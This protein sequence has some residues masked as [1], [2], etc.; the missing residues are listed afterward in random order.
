MLYL[1]IGCNI[2]LQSLKTQ[3]YLMI[4]TAM[5]MPMA[6]ASQAGALEDA[7]PLWA[8]LT[9]DLY[10]CSRAFQPVPTFIVRSGRFLCPGD[11][12]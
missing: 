5:P 12:L 6:G 2:S 11:P 10:V 8:S 9:P 4:A 7:R 3:V 1:Q